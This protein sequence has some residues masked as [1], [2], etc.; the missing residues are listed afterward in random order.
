MPTIIIRNKQT[1]EEFEGPTGT[2]FDSKQFEVVGSEGYGELPVKSQ[3]FKERAHAQMMGENPVAGTFLKTLADATRFAGPF[4]GSPGGT[5]GVSAASSGSEALAE[6]IEEPTLPDGQGGL[7][8][9]RIGGAAALPAFL[10]LGRG[11]AGGLMGGGKLMEKGLQKGGAESVNVQPILDAGA[12]IRQRVGTPA[13]EDK[14]ERL[15]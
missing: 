8:P 1:G 2:P 3:P 6:K 13:V 5:L 15:L 7:S 12:T 11:V 9:A 10:R 4:A 14:V